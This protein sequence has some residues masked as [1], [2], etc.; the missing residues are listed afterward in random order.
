[1]SMARREARTQRSLV[2]IRPE[3]IYD[4]DPAIVTARPD[5]GI[6]V[7][8]RAHDGLYWWGHRTRS[9]QSVL[10]AGGD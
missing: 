3:R 7:C 9:I 4:L 5:L 1:M 10:T 2:L 6:S 8:I